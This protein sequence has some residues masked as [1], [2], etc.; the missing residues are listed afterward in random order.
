MREVVVFALVDR[1][2]RGEAAVGG[3]VGAAGKG[4]G[5]V[6]GAGVAG[7]V[8]RRAGEDHPG[9]GDREGEIGGCAEEGVGVGRLWVGCVGGWGVRVGVSRGRRGRGGEAEDWA[10]D[11]EPDP[12]L[13]SHGCLARG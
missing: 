11:E 9:G 7:Y 4:R 5:V 13:G 10:G 3:A 6:A 8:G 12:G 1:G 2:A